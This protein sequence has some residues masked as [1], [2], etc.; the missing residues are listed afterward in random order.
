MLYLLLSSVYLVLVTLYLINQKDQLLTQLELYQ[1]AESSS[2]ILTNTSHSLRLINTNLLKGFINKQPVDLIKLMH[3]EFLELQK[4]YKQLQVLYPYSAEHFKDLVELLAQLVTKPSAVSSLKLK[5]GL[6]ENQTQIDKLLIANQTHTQLLLDSYHKASNTVALN[7]IYL[8]LFG[9]I[10][11]G[12]VL[13]LF[14][15]R[16]TQDISYLQQQIKKIMNG[17]RKQD[18]DIQRNDELQLLAHGINEM[19]ENLSSKEIALELERKK[20]YTQ[21]KQGAIEHLAAG[22]VH[23]MGN[24]VAALSGLLDCLQADDGYSDDGYCKESEEKQQ[25]LEQMNSYTKRMQTI[26]ED[27]SKLGTPLEKEIQLLDLNHIIRSHIGLWKLDE[28]SYGIKTILNLEPQLPVVNGIAEQLNQVLSN[29]IINSHEAL[30]KTSRKEKLITISTQ[31]VNQQTV[32][33]KI[34]DNGCGILQRTLENALDSL[35]TTR[36]M[37]MGKGLG[38]PLCR[39]ILSAHKGEISLTSSPG[40]GTKVNISLPVA[41]QDV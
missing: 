35:F 16:M 25:T 12:S 13:I 6:V 22:L 41:T 18:L 14:F 17:S 29:L 9:L 4:N 26:I 27:L 39:S 28:R 24:P 2:K 7:S 1:Q 3:G 19:A 21:Q 20:Q 11:F 8:G 34:E 40:D 10:L 36:N 5:Q 32:C 23:E 31:S 38:L 30:M 15:N 37:S 33:I